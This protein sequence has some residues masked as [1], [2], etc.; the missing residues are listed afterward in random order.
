[1]D[2]MEGPARPVAVEVARAHSTGPTSLPEI[3]DDDSSPQHSPRSPSMVLLKQVRSA[4]ERHPSF[5]ESLGL[6]VVSS[7]ENVTPVRENLMTSSISEGTPSEVAAATSESGLLMAAAREQPLWRRRVRHTFYVIIVI[8]LLGVVT[9][10]VALKRSNQASISSLSE[11]QSDIRQRSWL[12]KQTAGTLTAQAGLLAINVVMIFRGLQLWTIIKKIRVLET[13][14][15]LRWMEPLT[16]H[17]GRA[18]KPIVVPVKL[19]F[20]PVALYRARAEREAQAALLRE[21]AANRPWVVAGR[22]G[23]RVVSDVQ[24]AAAQA[25]MVLPSYLATT[26]VQAVR[27]IMP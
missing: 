5:A 3:L 12:Q 21:A 14:Q 24:M 7:S 27:Q 10:L 13:V 26:T 18:L 8:T 19:A 23:A 9:Q 1:M 15:R 17:T 6:R 4:L 20:R 11:V 2:V 16:R 22:H 25:A